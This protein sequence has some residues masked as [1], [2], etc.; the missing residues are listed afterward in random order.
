MLRPEGFG[1]TLQVCYLDRLV[2]EV[3]G[4]L[5]LF[6]V[7]SG[8][9]DGEGEIVVAAEVEDVLVTLSKAVGGE[10]ETAEAV[11]VVGVGSGKVDGEVGLGLFEGWGEGGL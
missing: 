7:P 8:E 5:H 1:K 6:V 11:V 9:G 3:D 10:G 2:V 4:G